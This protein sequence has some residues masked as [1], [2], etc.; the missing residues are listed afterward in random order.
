MKSILFCRNPEDLEQAMDILFQAGYAHV[1]N[2]NG[3][4]FKT[5]SSNRNNNYR[6]NTQYNR[7]DSRNITQYKNPQQP[8]NRQNFQPMPQNNGRDHQQHRPYQQPYQQHRPYQQPFQQH[9]PYQQPFQQHRPY[10]QLSITPPYQ[11]MTNWIIIMVTLIT[12]AK[13]QTFDIQD[14]SN[15]NGYIP[16]KTGNK[17]S[18]RLH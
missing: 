11:Q 2:N 17:N 15:N 8:F 14:L 9:R 10:Q 5:H 4:E 3:P 16:I 18:R 13:A 7:R 1:G 6:S 12:T